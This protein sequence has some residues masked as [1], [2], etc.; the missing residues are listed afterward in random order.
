VWITYG[1]TAGFVLG[2]YDIS[3]K[4]GM[5]GNSVFPVVFW[6]S[7]FGLICWLPIL[8]A[9]PLFKLHD[10]DLLSVSGFLIVLPKSIAM[11]GSWVLA[12]YA[13]KHLPVSMAGAVRA[14]GLV[15]PSLEGY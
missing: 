10:F 14:S 5:I 1:L 12:Y 8:I 2:L 4:E 7:L 15:G 3:T 11:T 6:S 9:A 13:V